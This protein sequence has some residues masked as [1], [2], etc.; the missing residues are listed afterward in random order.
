[1]PPAPNVRRRPLQEVPTQAKPSATF[2]NS[3]AVCMALMWPTH[4]TWSCLANIAVTQFKDCQFVRRKRQKLPTIVKEDAT[5]YYY[6][7]C[8]FEAYDYPGQR[9]SN[10]S[11]TQK[12][13]RSA[14]PEP[15]KTRVTRV[16]VRQETYDRLD[17][18]APLRAC[19]SNARY[20]VEL[21]FVSPAT[22]PSFSLNACETSISLNLILPSS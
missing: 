22:L 17:K 8:S 10:P 13:V 16:P 9:Q 6:W 4:R 21:Q 14:E 15:A 3:S 1:M 19:Q 20:S 2:T 12:I 5:F 11:R 7:P 18:R